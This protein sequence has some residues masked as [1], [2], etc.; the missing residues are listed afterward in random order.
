MALAFTNLVY[1]HV[2]QQTMVQGT[3]AFDSSYPTGGEP[4]TAAMI[5]AGVID[6]MSVPPHMGMSFEWD[7]TN[8]KILA[9]VQGVTI[10]AAGAATL[11]DF[12]ISGLGSTASTSVS[13]NNDAAAGV[14]HFGVQKEVAA[15]TNLS[16]VTGARF[17]AW[18]VGA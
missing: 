17:T 2:G 7:K 4:V 5:G 11:D 1:N 18:V 14:I 3:L 16:T 13:L 10:G 6:H 15:S 9:Y 12:P 8:S